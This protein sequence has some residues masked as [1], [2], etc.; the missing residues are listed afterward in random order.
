M[1]PTFFETPLQFRAW[2]EA[3]HASAAELVVGFRKVGTGLAS[4]TWPE[5]VDEALTAQGRMRPPGVAAFQ[6][7]TESKTGVYVFEQEAPVELP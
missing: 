2:L 3:N 4:M 1:T 7:R 5:S 6:A